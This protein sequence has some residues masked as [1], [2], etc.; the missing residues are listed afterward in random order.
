MKSLHSRQMREVLRGS[1]QRL[2]QNGLAGVGATGTPDLFRSLRQKGPASLVG[3]PLS[4]MAPDQDMG[5]RC[6]GGGAPW[7]ASG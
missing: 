7:S 2:G 1:N 3:K 4:H 6:Q 5:G